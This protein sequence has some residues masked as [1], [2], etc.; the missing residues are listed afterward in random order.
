MPKK[1]AVIVESPAKSRTINK[2]LGPD[3]LVLSSMGHIV[4][5]PR[6]KMAIDTENDFK[7]EYIVIPARRKHLAELKKR[8]KKIEMVY[9][10]PDPDR[11]GEAISWHLKQRL[12]KGKKVLRVTFD[13]ITPGA[14][15]KAFQNPRDI[16]PNLVNA[17]QARRILD[18]I[19]GYSLSPILW[20]KV[21]RGLSAG[22]V[23]SVAVRF[24]VERE[25][26][27]RKFKPEEYW[28][29]EA[30]LGKKDK[31]ERRHFTAGLHKINKKPP[32]IKS[33]KESDGIIE[34]IKKKEFVVSSVKEQNRKKHPTPPF[35]TSKLQQDAFN[36]LRFTVHKTMRVAQQLYEGV[37]L[38]GKESV[39]LI[40]YMRTDSVRV[41]DDARGA[42]RDYI[43]KTYGK[44]YYPH[45]PNIYKSRKS[46]QE[47]HE[48][49]RPTMPLRDPARLKHFL[50]ADQFKLY[51]LIWKRFISSQM[52]Q[53]AY[54]VTS[55]EIEAGI[56]LFR[57]SGTKT[58]FDGFTVLYPAGG[59]KKEGE[60]R[61]ALWSI[62]ALT[63]GEK[64]NLIKLLPSQ[65]FTKPPAR[66]S[67]ATLVKALEEAGIGRPSTYAPII[68]TIIMRNYVNRIRGYLQAT[69]LGEITNGLLVK[70]FPKILDAGFT[71][72]LEDELDGIEEGTA[73]W[74]AVLKTFYSPF[75]HNVEEAKK[76]MRSVKKEV[77]KT[78]ESCSLCG[79]HMV[80]KW[81]RRG[82][83]LSCSD[84][85]KCKYAKSITTG[86]KCPAPGCDGELI[87][88]RSNRGPFYGCTR[89]PN[90]KHISK[91]LPEENKL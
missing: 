76:H 67:D 80:I 17:Q 27:I 35:T 72:K 2:I 84:F 64:L 55:V 22:R 63:V 39:G 68:S 49:I 12:G 60:K 33:K 74:L 44:K 11:E 54:A 57:A 61:E 14:V 73:D 19:V 1:K 56:Y 69:E 34:D 66:Y 52:A 8:I 50:A 24:V 40:T 42:A 62:P 10:A 87:E 83:F 77:V 81:G 65:H 7:P 86:V 5:L 58:V 18:R 38:G 90:C 45:K 48:C 30:H 13:E 31:S 3:Y 41:S 4:D 43:L 15:K 89:Y 79:K 59:V 88:R 32:H 70:H 78:D 9:L 36:K 28:D 53:A 25:R 71:A 85:P 20:R 26:A 75:I 47:A 21:T 46:A 91:T 51:E 82:K 29:I 6:T 23:Q 16:D 37:D